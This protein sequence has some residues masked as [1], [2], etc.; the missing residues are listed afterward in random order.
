MS[1]PD[2]GLYFP[3]LFD[4][5]V[6][7]GLVEIVAC[8]ADFLVH[9]VFIIFAA[10]R[11]LLRQDVEQAVLLDSLLHLRLVVKKDVRQD[12]TREPSRLIG[13]FDQSHIRRPLRKGSPRLPACTSGSSRPSC[14]RTE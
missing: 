3:S 4:Q 7:N 6:D 10:F 9:H 14:Y 5:D 1:L 8:A 12:R 13:V 11:K 2:I